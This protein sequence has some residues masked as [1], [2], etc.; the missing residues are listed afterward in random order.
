MASKGAIFKVTHS[1]SQHHL[2]HSFGMTN[3]TED[4]EEEEQ[5]QVLESHGGHSLVNESLET[6]GLDEVNH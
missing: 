5:F 2:P 6:P 4:E 3:M 1:P